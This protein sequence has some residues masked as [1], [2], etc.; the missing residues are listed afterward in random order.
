MAMRQ[1]TE[2][3][4]SELDRVQAVR[5]LLATDAESL[6]RTRAE[7]GGLGAEAAEGKGRARAY[8]QKEARDKAMVRYAL[9]GLCAIAA[10]ICA[11]RILWFVGGVRLPGL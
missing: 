4:R 10:Y 2:Q 5:S 6:E 8:A 3:L 11:R 9:Y 1:T 7:H